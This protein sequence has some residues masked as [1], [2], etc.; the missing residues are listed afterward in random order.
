[1]YNT[2]L[3]EWLYMFKSEIVCTLIGQDIVEFVNRLR[4]NYAKSLIESRS[5]SIT[6]IAAMA[7]FRD[8]KYFS[9][10]F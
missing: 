2:R 1:M 3:A 10:V 7:G 8:E 9:Q 4:V 5:H 6:E